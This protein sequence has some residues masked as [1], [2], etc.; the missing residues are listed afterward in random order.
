M[1]RP[2]SDNE[3]IHLNMNRDIIAQMNVLLT[4]PA[5]GRLRYGALTSITNKLFGQFLRGF[6]D[7]DNK[8][9]YLKAY[10]VELE[11]PIKQNNT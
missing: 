7:A 11:Q 2:K 4:D 5:T 6:N 9:A 3:R 8:I 1:P 10:G